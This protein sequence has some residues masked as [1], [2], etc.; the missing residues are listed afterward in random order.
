MR[1]QA[2]I[3]LQTSMAPAQQPWNISKH[4]RPITSMLVLPRIYGSV[5]AESFGGSVRSM[6]SMAINT[7]GQL[8]Q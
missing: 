2:V 8:L 6:A 1:S 4:E 7:W 3:S 5:S